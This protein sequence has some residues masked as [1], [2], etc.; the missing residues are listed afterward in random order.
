M[1]RLLCLYIAL[2]Y[3]TPK[4]HLWKF[5]RMKLN[6]CLFCPYSK[7]GFF[8]SQHVMFDILLDQENFWYVW[9]NVIA[10]TWNGRERTL[11]RHTL[12]GSK[13]WQ[14]VES[15]LQFTT[16]WEN[17]L[18]C[19]ILSVDNFCINSSQL[20]GKYGWSFGKKIFVSDGLLIIWSKSVRNQILCW[21]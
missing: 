7:I 1:C 11:K 16:A 5:L 19:H 13:G 15:L 4:F 14:Q 2:F 12:C 3:H 17:L 18:S 10:W 21:L 8:S 6:I 9:G 20:V